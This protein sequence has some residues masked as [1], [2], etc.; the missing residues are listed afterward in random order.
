MEYFFSRF[1]L[2]LQDN[3]SVITEVEVFRYASGS[4]ENI[5][6]NMVAVIYFDLATFQS[7]IIFCLFVA[8]YTF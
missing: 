7:G 5:S 4:F 6:T 3:N 1:T 8:V 2:I